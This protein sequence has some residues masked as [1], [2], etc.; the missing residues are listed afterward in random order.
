M[1]QVVCEEA[2]DD[3]VYGQR[4]TQKRRYVAGIVT[5]AQP[6]YMHGLVD[7]GPDVALDDAAP[8]LGVSASVGGYQVE[9]PLQGAA[10]VCRSKG[11]SVGRCLA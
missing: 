11:H 5:P 8:L 10:E 6:E 2:P 7:G 4:K 3:H 1:L 9:A